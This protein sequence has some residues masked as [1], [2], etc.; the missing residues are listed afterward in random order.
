MLGLVW[1]VGCGWDG[2]TDTPIPFEPSPPASPGEASFRAEGTFE[3][4]RVVGLEV[5]NPDTAHLVTDPDVEWFTQQTAFRLV[6]RWTPDGV[7]GVVMEEETC[8]MEVSV[9]GGVDTVPGPRLVGSLLPVRLDAR[10]EGERPG[11]GVTSAPYPDVWGARLDAPLTDSMPMS[12]EDASAWDQDE[13]GHPGVTLYLDVVDSDI[14]WTTYVA[15][16][17]I[18]TLD[19]EVYDADRVAGA[20]T[21]SS[22]EQVLFEAEPGWLTAVEPQVRPAADPALSYFEA[23]RVSDGTT[24]ADLAARAPAPPPG[25][26]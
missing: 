22:A 23:T 1:A 14:R 17:V 7:G 2:A 8:T 4:L 16:R 20:V 11:D 26:F 24:C 6:S 12:G 9:I 21:V 13:D 15:Q 25:Q 18:F 10:I 3:V 19:A 5:K